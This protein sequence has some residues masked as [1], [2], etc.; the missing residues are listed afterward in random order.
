MP[1]FGNNKNN[2]TFSFGPI[3]NK[4]QKGIMP[5]SGN[6]DNNDNNL[7]FNKKEINHNEKPIFPPL[8]NNINNNFPFFNKRNFEDFLN[9]K[10][11]DKSCLNNIKNDKENEDKTLIE[12]KNILNSQ[13]SSRNFSFKQYENPNNFI[14]NIDNND[15][16]NNN[17]N[18]NNFNFLSNEKQNQNTIIK[19]EIMDKGIN[20]PNDI[21][22]RIN[23][24]N[25]KDENKNNEINKDENNINNHQKLNLNLDIKNNNN[26]GDNQAFKFTGCAKLNDYEKSQ[27]LYKTNATIIGE[28]QL[29]LFLQQ[30][31]F[32]ECVENTRKIEDKFRNIQQLS[33]EYIQITENNIIKSNKLF[34]KLNHINEFSN[35]L[36]GDVTNSNNLIS[37]ALLKYKNNILNNGNNL[38]FDDININDKFKYF[39]DMMDISRKCTK[40]ENDINNSRHILNEK[41]KNYSNKNN[42]KDGIVIERE[43]KKEI[44]I[45]QTYM[46]ILLSDCYEGLINLN[47]MQEKFDSKYELLK[48]KLSQYNKK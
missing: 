35:K 47:N 39:E 45:N 11:K 14:N 46:N 20:N 37:N 17:I 15:K 25:N 4:T 29:I 6:K 10:S 23:N 31:K 1:L 43:N 21:F 38:L 16:Q 36:K 32:K 41:E 28:F 33:K 3:N 12:N 18:L 27:L 44:L 24:R 2:P 22:S 13:F 7:L 48:Q 26:L 42:N 5:I 30:E 40:I 8:N 34:E 9:N 19:N